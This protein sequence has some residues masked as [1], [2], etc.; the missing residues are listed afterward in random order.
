MTSTIAPGARSSAVTHLQQQLA[1][2]GLYK[3]RVDGD[4]G[5]ITKKAVSSFEKQHQLKADGVADG[6]T[7]DALAKATAPGPVKQGMSGARVKSLQNQLQRLGLYKA[8]VD[9]SFGP[10]TKAAVQAFERKHGWNPDGVAGA[11]VQAA[12]AKEV[13]ALPKPNWKTVGPPPAD[14][15]IVSFRGVRVN[16]RTRVMIERAESYMKQMGINSKLSFSQG[17][18]NTSVSASA[19]THD[20]GGALDIRIGGYSSATA[21]NVVKALR[22]AGFAAWHRGVNDSFDPHIHA[23]AIGDTRATQVAKNQVSEYRRGGDGLVGSAG[24]IHLTSRGHNIG[25]PVPNWAR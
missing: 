6:R 23:I 12:L 9:G 10:V 5:P 2:L 15:R 1:K 3:A 18:Y 13:K 8:P 24:D 25:R 16:V 7:R 22:M 20:G 4:Y 11:R 14:Y 21:D 19:G 17:S